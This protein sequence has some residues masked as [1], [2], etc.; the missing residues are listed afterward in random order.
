MVK[1]TVFGIVGRRQQ[2]AGELRLEGGRIVSVADPGYPADQAGHILRL[3]LD[4]PLR[5][6]GKPVSARSDPEGFLRGLCR[7]YTG[8]Y[9]RVGKAEA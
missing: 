6:D 9:V 8:T 2:V 1:A 3:V 7:Q 5:V 4:S